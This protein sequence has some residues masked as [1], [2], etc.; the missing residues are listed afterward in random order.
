[1]TYVRL[2][3]DFGGTINITLPL[4]AGAMLS[5]WLVTH[6]F[7]EFRFA[8]LIAFAGTFVAAAG[9]FL[10]SALRTVPPDGTQPIPAAAFIVFALTLT[11]ALVLSGMIGRRGKG[12]IGTAAADHTS[13]LAD[14]TF[15]R[16]DRLIDIL[17]PMR[18]L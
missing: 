9:V 3:H 6:I 17:R 7:A 2:R 16:L 18:R 5:G 10:V 15:E 1:M 11:L 12:Y 13:K 14:R 4:F 8:V